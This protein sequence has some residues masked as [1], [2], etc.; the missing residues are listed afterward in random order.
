MTISET[1]SRIKDDKPATSESRSGNR[2][3]KTKKADGE[4]DNVY[5]A[6]FRVEVAAYYKAL[7]RGFAPG[8]ELDDWLAAE[9]E[10]D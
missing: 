9:K 4:M 5:D 3:G 1:Q 7:A 10:T 2:M 8:H 6:R